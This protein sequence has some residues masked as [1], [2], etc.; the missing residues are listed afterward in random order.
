[1]EWQNVI[2]KIAPTVASALLGPAGGVAVSA[3]T[4]IFGLGETASESDI[5]SHISSGKLTGEQIAAIRELE[6]KLQAEEKERGF[7]FS[8]LEF[9]DRNSARERDSV[10]VKMG[11]HNL[12][13]DAMFILAVSVIC[14]LVY[15]IW[16]DQTINEFMKGIVTLVLG[17]FL[18]YLDN[19]YSFEFGTTRGSQSKDSTI[20]KLSE[21]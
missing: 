18:G 10:F 3:L 20:N 1:M 16:K 14:A 21:K 4:S 17:R 2:A 19:I 12:R 7:R 15:M 9:K 5:E 8:E 6:L 13:A 11:R